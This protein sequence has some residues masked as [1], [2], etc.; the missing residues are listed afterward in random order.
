VLTKHLIPQLL[1][2]EGALFLKAMNNLD[3]AKVFQKRAVHEAVGV[4]SAI[5]KDEVAI[6]QLLNQ[7]MGFFAGFAIALVAQ[8][9]GDDADEAIAP[10]QIPL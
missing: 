6:A 7:Q 9:I 10:D 1:K 3:G 2:G 5:A 8:V 4:G